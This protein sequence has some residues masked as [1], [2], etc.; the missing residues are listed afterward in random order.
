MIDAYEVGIKLA[1]EDGAT[2]GLDAIL[3]RL[4]E[5]DRAVNVVNDGLL[6]LSRAAIPSN[7]PA[8]AARPQGL[9]AALPRETQ[10]SGPSEAPSPAKPPAPEQVTQRVSEALGGSSESAAPRSDSGTRPTAPTEGVAKALS[11]PPPLAAAASQPPVQAALPQPPAA[12]TAPVRT[13]ASVQSSTE[14][15]PRLGDPNGAEPMS[16]VKGVDPIPSAQVA[17]PATPTVSPQSQ[18]VAPDRR[19]SV[20]AVLRQARTQREDAERPTGAGQVNLSLTTAY[21]VDQRTAMAPSM[22]LPG[23]HAANQVYVHP[24]TQGSAAPQAAARDDAQGMSGTVMLD[25]RQVGQWITDQLARQASRPPSGTTFFDPKQGP[26]WN[27]SG[28]M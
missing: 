13:G 10:G 3:S 28:A 20:V 27:S 4:A 15:R 9:A 5:V 14:G 12:P 25:G 18:V 8:A 1:L 16:P 26:A 23:P 7:S 17:P 2:S 22:S 21:S 11:A 19:P 24:P 6:A